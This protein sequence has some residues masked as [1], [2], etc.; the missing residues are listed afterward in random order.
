MHSSI[1]TA[2][3]VT[4]HLFL[5]PGWV[6]VVRALRVCGTRWPLLLGTCPCALVVAGGLPLWRASWPRVLRRASSGPV[7]LGAPVG[8]PDAVVPFLSP[9]GLR[10][11]LYWVAARGTRRPAENRAHCACRWPPPRQGRWARSALYL[12]GAPRWGCPWRVPLASVLGC[13]RCGGWR[14]WTRSLTRPVFA[15]RPSFEGGLGR[16]TGAVSCGRRHLPLRVVCLCSS[17]LAGSGS[18]ASRAHSGAPHLFLWPLCLSLLLGPLRAGVAPF[19][20]QFFFSSFVVF[21]AALLCLAFFGFRP[22]VPWALA[23]WLPLLTPPAS[24]CFAPPP[25]SFL[26]H[27]SAPPLSLAFFGFRPRVPWASALCVVCVVL[28]SF[29]SSARPL[30]AAWWLPPPP[31]PPSL[32]VSRAFRRLRQLPCFFSLLRAPPLSPAFSGF[33]PWLPRALALCVVCFVGLPLLG[34]PGALV[35]FVSPAWPLAAPLWLLP[36]PPLCVSRFSSLPLGAPFVFSLSLCASVVSRFFWFP[37]PGA[38]G[39]G[40]VCCLRCWPLAS[41]LSTR[42]RLFC[43]FRLAV[44]SSLLAAAPPPPFVSRGFHRRRSVLCAMCC[45][46]LCVPGCGAAPR[47]GV[48]RLPVLCCCV[49]CCFVALVVALPLVVPHSVV[50]PVARGPVLCG[51]VFCGVP[52]RCVLC[53]V[54]ALSWRVGAR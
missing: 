22:R 42:S 35:S 45:P 10:P 34:S 49:L 12:F 7:A 36:P 31:P 3:G 32:F 18:P 40:A 33:R 2:A 28:A 51:A 6:C 16:C 24:L 25:L 4:W 21:L 23:P 8:F 47:C 54:C 15:Y 14:V 27:P 5:C 20:V 17:V 13:V 38:L 50:L 26:F 46:V 44:G 52:P 29:V 43:V 1:R 19:F 9:G 53:A 41:P 11:R 39:L 48:P 30:A 37:A